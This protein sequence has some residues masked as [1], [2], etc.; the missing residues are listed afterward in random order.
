MR[1]LQSKQNKEYS[2]KSPNSDYGVETTIGKGRNWYID[3]R[4]MKAPRE[5][6]IQVGP[7]SIGRMG[8]VIE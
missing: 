5:G 6:K 7:W 1:N 4:S 2:G 8:K 3:L